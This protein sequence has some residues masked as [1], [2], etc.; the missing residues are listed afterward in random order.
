VERGAAA[1][2]LLAAPALKDAVH[3]RST[4]PDDRLDDMQ[5]LVPAFE[6]WLA[7]SERE[8][9]VPGERTS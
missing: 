9:A 2:V 7:A 8:A 3:A 4:V 6:A 5:A 1:R